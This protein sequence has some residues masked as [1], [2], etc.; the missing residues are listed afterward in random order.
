MAE[1]AGMKKIAIGKGIAA[2]MC[3]LCL[4]SCGKQERQDNGQSRILNL[5]LDTEVSTL[6]AQAAVDSASLEVI[7]SMMEGLY[8]M[9]QDDRP[10]PAIAE[11][12]EVSEDGLV[13]RFYLRD[14]F[15]S[16]GSPVTAED[17]VYGFQRAADPSLANEN[18][19]LLETAGILNGK[20]AA[21]GQV[22]LSSLGIRAVDEKV[23]EIILE[24]PVPYFCS[25]LAF[26][27]FFPAKKEFVEQWD[28]G[29]ARTGDAILCNGPYMMDSYSPSG[30]SFT[31]K[32]NPFYRGKTGK[33]DEIH[34]QVI[35]DSQQALLAY[36]K[37]E[38]DVAPLSGGQAELLKEQEEFHSFLLG[39]LWY[40]SPN[41]RVRGLEN[42]NLR[43]ALAISF[44]RE[45]AAEYIMKDGS[46]PAG[47]AVPWGMGRG[48]DGRDFREDGRTYLAYD[49]EQAA[50]YWEQA[51]MEMGIGEGEIL[52]YTLLVE[53]TQAAF[54]LAQYFQNQIQESLP[55]IQIQ[56]EQVPKKVRLARMREGDYELGLVRWG[57][58]YGDPTAFLQMWTTDSPY[59]YGSWSEE[60][61]DAMLSYGIKGFQK[62]EEEERWEVLKQ[63]EAMVMEEA[64]I[65]P[66]CQKANAFMVRKGLSGMEFHPVGINRVFWMVEKEEEKG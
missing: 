63:A 2:F 24:R 47:F 13:Y 27:L 30:L 18:A 19:F 38:L 64:V 48:P 42:K 43:K 58:D 35:R 66:I 60:T 11:R 4:L 14:S 22:P 36:Q 37:G 6:D 61:Y 29:Y 3:L 15:W 55:G 20:K 34:Y 65:F 5:S 10:V 49:R 52:S 41:Q 57:G 46:F 12:E 25:M 17:F 39:S 40:I 8:F 26:P 16:D 32:R 7:G 50:E 1:R 53:D 28:S 44:N 9:D 33:I 45:A 23:L 54:L 31:L 59:N 21:E 62:G 56:V 51:K